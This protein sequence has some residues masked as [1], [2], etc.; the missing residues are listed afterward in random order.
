MTRIV[1]AAAILLAAAT[2]AVAADYP[3]HPITLVVPLVAGSSG[4]ILA[5]T[6]AHE[7]TKSFGQTVVVDNRPGAGGGIGMAQVARAAPDG[8]TIAVIT[9]A[10]H[11]FNLGLYPKLDYDPLK[12]FVAI[13]PA[14]SVSNVMIVH[15]SNPAR[16]V[17]DVIAAAKARPGALTFS[18]GGNG[19]SH[20]LSGVLFQRMTG[21]ELTHVPYRGAPQGIAAVMS[22]EANLGFFNTP[23]VIAQIRDGKLRGL[24]VTSLQRSP[25]LPE[26]STLDEEGIKGYEMIV[27]FGFGAPARTPPAVVERWHAEIAR[28]VADAGFRDRMNNLGF[29]MMEPLAP[30][31]FSQFIKADAEKWVPIVK[32][33]GATV[34]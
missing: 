18:S 9:Q 32:A 21:T 2:S 23:T 19:L 22:N 3:A 14:A 6:V 29:D 8:Y 13:V 4:D 26:L 33:S 1:A 28:L 10:T 11:V 15:P 27:W 30:A 16:R 7:V 25:Q 24:G 20:H 31:A 34:D 5:R 17:A 12:D